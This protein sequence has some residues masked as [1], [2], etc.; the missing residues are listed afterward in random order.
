MEKKEE[1]NGF[2][3]YEKM[4]ETTADC[5]NLCSLIVLGMFRFDKIPSK[6]I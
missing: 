6:S 2:L 4:A 5:K 3:P 1:V